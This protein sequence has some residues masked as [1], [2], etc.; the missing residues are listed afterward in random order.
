MLFLEAE[1]HRTVVIAVISLT[2]MLE[3]Q[4]HH[5][6]SPLSVLGILVSIERV[7]LKGSAVRAP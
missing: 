3:E 6:C 7:G 2:D 5:V 1:G 4:R